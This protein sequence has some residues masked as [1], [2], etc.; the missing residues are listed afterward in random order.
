MKDF[1]YFMNLNY[2]V[3][4]LKDEVE[5]GYIF[6]IPELKGCITCA[7]SLSNGYEMILDAKRQW[8][9]AALE[10][11]YHIPEPKDK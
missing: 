1:N 2:R 3:E 9:I 4:I 6:S 5:G 7:D 10:D 11:N 8:F